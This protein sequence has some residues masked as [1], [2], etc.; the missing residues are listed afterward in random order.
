MNISNILKY[1][2]EVQRWCKEKPAI[3][4]IMKYAD[5]L[6]GTVRQTGV[7][8]CGIIIA[9]DDLTNFVPLST[10][11]E[12]DK[13]K[14]DT[15]VL[16]TQYDGHVIEQI[17]LIKMDFLALKTLS[18]MKETVANIKKSKNIDLDINNIDMQR[19]IGEGD[20]Y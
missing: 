15:E 1:S 17:G 19:T 5:Q 8:A 14:K 3:A 4:E 13:S 20:R 11:K 6:E 10:A 18:I 7:H 2:K 9:P 16:V 12:K